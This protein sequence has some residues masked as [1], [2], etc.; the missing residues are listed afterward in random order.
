MNE[1]IHKMKYS[2][3]QWTEYSFRRIMVTF[4]VSCLQWL[5][6]PTQRGKHCNKMGRMREI[7]RRAR[8]T[9]KH[10]SEN[11]AKKV[12]SHCTLEIFYSTRD[13]CAIGAKSARTYQ[14]QYSVAHRHSLVNSRQFEENVGRAARLRRT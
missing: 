6:W 2:R 7:H 10:L 3:L 13:S 9:D 5:F 1:W 14:S 8:V 11:R 4:D 12:G